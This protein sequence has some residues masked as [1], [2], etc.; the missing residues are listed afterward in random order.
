MTLPPTSTPPSTP[1][2]SEGATTET[3][4]ASTS[5]PSLFSR[6]RLPILFVILIGLYYYA[7]SSGILD[8]ANPDQIRDIVQQ[9]GAYGAVLFIV[10]F[11]VGQLLY[12]PGI[13]FVIAAG[14][15]Y[16]GTLG[17]IIGFIGAITA[18]TVSFFA[19]RL[20]GGSPLGSAKKPFIAKMLQ[21]L[22]DRP[23]RNIAIMRLVVSTAPWLNY[24]LALSSVK[25][26][27]YI[28]GSVLGMTLPIATTIYFTDWLV[29]RMF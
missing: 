13:F 12:V 18:I 25:Y 6:L 19:V 15:I 20:I 14:I 9:W 27:Q 21:G 8:R 24:I 28:I 5:P 16:G 17:F 22:H 4:A 1:A 10:L 7:R 11:T 23:I 3:S 26:R 29:I 2:T